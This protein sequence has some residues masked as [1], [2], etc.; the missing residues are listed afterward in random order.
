MKTYLISFLAL[1]LALILAACGGG[2]ASGGSDPSAVIEA[3][4]TA[5]NAKDVDAAMAL[6]TDDA[7]ET[8]QLGT[9]T[10]KD[11]IRGVYENVM[12]DFS[13]DCKNYQVNGNTVSYDCIL[14]RYDGS[15]T[16]G[17][18]YDSVVENGKI[19]S[20]TLTG[21]FTP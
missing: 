16:A 14:T 9:F 11:A 8:N 15:A 2:G 7:E 19:K 6:F 17:E 10:G 12:N 18:R 13:M 21:T 20:N 5:W 3:L 4:E 1:T